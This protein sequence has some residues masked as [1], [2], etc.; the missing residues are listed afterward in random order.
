M[1]RVAAQV[2]YQTPALGYGQ[3]HRV[4]REQEPHDRAER[5]EQRAVE[6]LVARGGSHVDSI[7]G[8]SYRG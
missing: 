7:G 1:Q 5:R 3:Q 6:L 4:E 8:R 2:G